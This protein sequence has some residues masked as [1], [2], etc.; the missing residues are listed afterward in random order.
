MFRL[1]YM[2]LEKWLGSNSSLRTQPVVY[3]V[4]LSIFLPTLPHFSLCSFS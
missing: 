3:S 1:N 2:E 4:P